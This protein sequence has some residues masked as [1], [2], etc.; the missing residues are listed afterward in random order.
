M[1]PKKLR[2]VA[3]ALF[4]GAATA[5]ACGA[6]TVTPAQAAVRAVVGKPLQAAQ[7]AA[8]AGN[9]SAAMARVREAESVGGLTAEEQKIIG[10]MRDYIEAKSGGSVGVSSA[11]GAQAKFDADYRAGRYHD[12][13]DDADLLR[14]YGALSGANMV[15]IAQAYYRMGAYKECAHYAADHSGV[16][17]DML[18]LQMRCAYEAHDDALIR[19]ASEQLVASSG[20]PEHWAQLLKY[21]ESAKALSDHQTL[22]INR[23]KL[24]TGTLKGDSDY[25]LLATL[26]MQFGYPSE[27][28]SVIQ[29]GLQAKVLSGDRTN[30]LMNMAKGSLGPD[31]ANLPK[32]VAAANKAK[33]GDLLV[34]L[35][36][37]YCGMGRYQDAVAAVQA[38][39]AKGV[40]DNDNAETRLGQ[41]LYG[42]GQK[43]AALKAFAKVKNTPNGEMIARLWSLYVRAH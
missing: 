15:V 20:T 28:V 12:A 30:R 38:G 16:G 41:A 8:A 26:A 23:I 11:V 10:Q 25:F 31:L 24:L 7:A 43:E 34:K 36:E 21:A 13:I 42:A 22:D 6:L 40:S 3:T 4:L 27:A 18:E 19:S 29:K 9:Y 14:R 37:D 39:I 1:I 2:A 32:T 5:M 17:S 35:G 33:N